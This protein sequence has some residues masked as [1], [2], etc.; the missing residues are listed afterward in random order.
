MAA[1]SRE[2]KQLGSYKDKKNRRRRQNSVRQL[3][4]RKVDK[5]HVEK[6]VHGECHALPHMLVLDRARV[7]ACEALHGGA[8][9]AVGS[10]RLQ[11]TQE[12]QPHGARKRRRGC[13]TDRVG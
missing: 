9:S 5:R 12:L 3:T 8:R 6:A 4:Q 7:H 11:D 2:E 10:E 1:V 13:S